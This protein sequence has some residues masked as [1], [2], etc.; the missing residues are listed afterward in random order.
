LKLTFVGTGSGKASLNRYHSSI[1]LS[2]N[3]NNILLDA[4][5]G[6]NRAL[7]K[8]GIEF[9]S[10]TGIIFSHFHPDHYT[11]LAALIVQMKMNSRNSKLDVY[12][13]HSLVNVLKNFL[14][15]SYLLPERFGF[16]INYIPFNEREIIKIDDELSFTAIPN[17]HLSEISQ[18]KNYEALSFF[19]AS[20][21]FQCSG[22]RIFYTADIGSVQ[23]IKISEAAGTEILITEV[24]HLSNE[25]ILEVISKLN[26]AQIYFT[27]ITDGEEHTLK[28]LQK[29][30]SSNP[31]MKLFI[32]EDGLMFNI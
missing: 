20:F 21:L 10:I 31:K 6:I 25:D 29:K 11:G 5:D 18:M 1:L 22:K 27:H 3:A 28:D 2:T 9:N 14:I 4:G 16:Q 19:S 13:H 32:A 12:V 17:T 23:D 15:T 8:T 30:L 24:T 26:T 7:L